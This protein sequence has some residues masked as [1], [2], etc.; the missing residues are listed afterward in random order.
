MTW[1]NSRALTPLKRDFLSSFFHKDQTF[2][3]TGGSALGIFYLEHRLSYDLD[4]FTDRDVDW[5]VVHNLTL[6]TAR[7]IAAQCESI[8]ASPL[9]RRYRLRRGEQQEIV[10]FVVEHEG[11]FHGIE[12]K[13]QRTVSG[14]DELSIARGIGAG[15]LVTR[16]AF[17]FAAIPRL[18]LWAFLLLQL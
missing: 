14:W 3:L 17:E 5:H 9:F 2:Y 8:T 16:D 13:F 11:R 18:P 4:F 6:A 12:V 7:E 1:E 10:D 15:L